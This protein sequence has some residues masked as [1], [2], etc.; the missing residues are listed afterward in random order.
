MNAV[1]ALGV[2]FGLTEHFGALG[3]RLLIAAMVTGMLTWRLHRRRWTGLLAF[4][5]LA[6]ASI[7]L[8][9]LP[10]RQAHRG[11]LLT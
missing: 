8:C 1:I 7:A 5:F 10:R 9:P 6:A 2:L 4:P 11:W 3:A